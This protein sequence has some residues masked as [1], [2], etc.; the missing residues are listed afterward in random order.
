VR[1]P[2]DRECTVECSAGV[3]T[4][5]VDAG[6]DGAADGIELRG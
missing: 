1:S 3:V 5:H 6:D 2:R 4:R